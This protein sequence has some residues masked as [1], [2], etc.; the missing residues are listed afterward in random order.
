[1]D[2]ISIIVP[3]Y[4]NIYIQKCLDSL[5]AQTIDNYEIICVDD[6][7]NDQQTLAILEEYQKKYTKHLKVYHIPNCGVWYARMYG[8]NKANGN[9]IGFCDS[10]DTVSSTMYEKLY[11]RIIE[12]KA[13]MAVCGFQR[14]NHLTKK[15]YSTEMNSLSHD[16][17]LPEEIEQMLLV[18][19]SL[20]NKLFSKT[21]IDY[22]MQL[23]NPPRIGEDMM[24]LLSIYPYMKRVTFVNEVLY[25]Y[26][27]YD[28]SSMHSV[29]EQ[30]C[31]DTLCAYEQVASSL[32]EQAKDI[33][34]LDLIDTMAFIHLG[35]AL[36]VTVMED[37]ILLKKVYKLTREVLDYKYSRYK[38]TS[39]L[40]V[41]H[42]LKYE[43][44]LLKIWF[45]KQIYL[46]HSFMLFLK[47]Y[48]FIISKLEKDIKW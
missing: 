42:I 11:R 28:N 10:D 9:F 46:T 15:V 12:K 22:V 7:S 32:K 35:I 3:V 17:E 45:M 29:T 1:M 44:R 39:M 24:F 27:V 21:C 4:N 14:I 47:V 2:L 23:N 33:K 30:A 16:I 41:L 5:L 34:I 43:K 40:Q 31:Y 25:Q 19:T 26:Y 48:C 36:P 38:T 37:K 6:G 13:D 20:W 8:I 18:N